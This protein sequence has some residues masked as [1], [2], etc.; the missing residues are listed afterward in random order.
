M[1]LKPVIGG[2]G[3][4][5]QP[6]SGGPGSDTTAVHAPVAGVTV[7]GPTVARAYAFPDAPATIARTDASQ[8]FTGTQFFLGRIT[9]GS[10]STTTAGFHFDTGIVA[11]S[12]YGGM[13]STAVSPSNTNYGLLVG[14]TSTYLNAP[15]DSLN[16][17]ISDSTK[18]RIFSGGGVA[19]GSLV[20]P[21]SN[22]LGVSGTLNVGGGTPIA[23]S[24]T[25]TAAMSASVSAGTVG[26]VTVTATGVAAGDTFA[27]EIPQQ[28]ASLVFAGVRGGTDQILV[29]FY[30]ADLLTPHSLSGTI[31]IRS[32]EV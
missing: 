17:A 22:N 8:T 15:S 11:G 16:L 7:T 6:S 12:G 25:Y 18:L 30:N 21:G 27:L 19:I 28:T 26:T 10:G 32:F 20:D 14:A 2:D 5:A 13:W 1:A 31:K 29:D 9:L 23:K 4:V 3:Y 24:A